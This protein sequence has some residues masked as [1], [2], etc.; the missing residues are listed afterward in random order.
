MAFAR[1][2]IPL[3]LLI[4]LNFRIL[5][6]V[7]QNK[8]KRKTLSTSSASSCATM[9]SN[10]NKSTKS[11]VTLMLSTIILTYVICMFPDAIMTMMQ[12]G[13]A[14]E[15]FL[16]RSVREITD[17]LLTINSAITFP[18]CFH[19]SHEF[20][21]KVKR[22]CC[23]CD[24]K[25]TNSRTTTSSK[26]SKSPH[27]TNMANSKSNNNNVGKI[28][29]LKKENVNLFDATNFEAQSMSRYVNNKTNKTEFTDVSIPERI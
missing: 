9:K 6:I 29:F 26:N 4:Y 25:K 15:S 5:R 10:R 8:M 3:L 27:K 24:Q 2:F 11:R 7:Y 17:L 1:A 14:N 19:F 22:L 20:K 18:I 13:Y 23:E 16:I 21:S 28:D 12:F